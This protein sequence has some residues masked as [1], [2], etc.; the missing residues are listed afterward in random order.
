MRASILLMAAL[1]SACSKGA[2]AD[3]QYI[4]EARSLAAEWAL[5]NEQ[6]AKG[7]LTDAYVSAMRT[8]LKEQAD[9][10]AKSLSQPNSDYAAEMRAIAAQPVDASPAGLRAHSDRLKQI[11]DQLESA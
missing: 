10:A 8:S 9:T 6:A 2:Q 4:A 11:E 5:L 1:L 7:K 3:L